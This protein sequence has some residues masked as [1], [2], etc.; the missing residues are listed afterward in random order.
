MVIIPYQ[1]GHKSRLLEIF[2]ENTPKYFAPAEQGDFEAYL[3]EHGKTY[4]IIKSMG[5]IAGGGGYHRNDYVGRLS[6]T[7]LDPAYY[8][9]G[10]GKALINFCIEQMLQNSL[11]TKIEVRT[12]QHAQAF[13]SKFGFNVVE[14]KKDFW[15]TGLDL[16]RMQRPT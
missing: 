6:W 13:Y 8:S 12:S 4:Y 15:G 5:I 1:T 7:M 14:H 3:S 10:L 11:I 9:Q 16:F 2:K